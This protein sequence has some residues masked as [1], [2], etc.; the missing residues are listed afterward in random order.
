[1]SQLLLHHLKS[2]IEYLKADG[3]DGCAFE[4]RK[5]WEGPCWRCKRNCKDYW[6][7]KGEQE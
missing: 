3:C 7:R 6:R 2:I 4:D 1:M 5:K